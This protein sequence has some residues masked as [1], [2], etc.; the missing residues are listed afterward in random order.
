MGTNSERVLCV[1]LCNLDI[2]MVCPSYPLEDSDQR[3][4]SHRWQR[5][6]NAS[7]SATIFAE[8]GVK[9]EFLG[10]VSLD[11]GGQFMKKNFDEHNICTENCHY[12]EEF[13]SPV[14]TIW[15]NSENGS[16]T[17]V[18][19]NKN[20]PEISYED[21]SALN[22]KDYSWIHFECRPNYEPMKANLE[23]IRRWNENKANNSIT[24]SIEV[25]K[26]SLQQT[27]V[28]SLGDVLF[29]S[30]DFAAAHGFSNM[31]DAV[32]TLSCKLRRG[33]TLICSWGE[34]GACAKSSD[35]PLYVSKAFPPTNVV[36][37]LGA[38][39]TFI[40]GSII[41]LMKGKNMQDA[42]I[43]GCKI[44]GTKC[45]MHDTKELSKLCPFL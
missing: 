14:S 4:I 34:K 2:V 40:A 32:E 33:A 3:C 10:T 18:H 8:Y 20:M 36:N 11:I 23:H 5:G 17:I 21:F 43:M 26:P 41:S 15:I 38:G 37:T 13:E 45:G 31:V 25:E 7:N 28:L 42:I 30:K 24:V 39:D 1:G 27:E 12:Y 9:C 16:R 44:A 22:L 6:G 19:A 29:I 35:G